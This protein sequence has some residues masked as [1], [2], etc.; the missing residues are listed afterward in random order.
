MVTM[1]AKNFDRSLT[2]EDVAR[3]EHPSITNEKIEINTNKQKK[4]KEKKRHSSD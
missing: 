2:E 3:I 4:R 1:I